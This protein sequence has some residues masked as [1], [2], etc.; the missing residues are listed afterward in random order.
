MYISPYVSLYI[1]MQ[2]HIVFPHRFSQ[3]PYTDLCCGFLRG[4]LQQEVFHRPV[5]WDAPYLRGINVKDLVGL[6]KI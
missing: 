2:I 1:S 6:H 3:Y 5:S 4:K